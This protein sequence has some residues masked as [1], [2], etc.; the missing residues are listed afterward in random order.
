MVIQTHLHVG[1][2]TIFFIKRASLKRFF[3]F[4][5]VAIKYNFLNKKV[6]TRCLSIKIFAWNFFH[7]Q[8]K[9]CN[10]NFTHSYNRKIWVDIRKNRKGLCL[11]WR[12]PCAYRMFLSFMTPVTCKKA[13]TSRRITVSV[14]KQLSLDITILPDIARCSVLILRFVDLQVTPITKKWSALKT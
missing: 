10:C 13:L 4:K 5:T 7:S 8:F 9:K 6:I 2:F 1:F 11:P 12:S 3:L 14:V